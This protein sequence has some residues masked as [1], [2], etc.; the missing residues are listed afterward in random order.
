MAATTEAPQI[1]L[2]ECKTEQEVIEHYNRMRQEQ[3]SFMSR[4]AATESE[5]HDHAL[6]LETLEGLEPTRRCH[7]LVGGVLVE[8][9]VAEVRPTIKQ[10]Q[11]NLDLLLKNLGD[12]LSKNEQIME[13]FMSKY[14]IRARG[15]DEP[16]AVAAN[17]DDGEGVKKSVLA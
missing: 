7:N 14:K 3:S 15:E 4:I 12:A 13:A 2:P 5:R 10:S 16:R 11:A 6:V 8:R 1:D 9:T 17:P